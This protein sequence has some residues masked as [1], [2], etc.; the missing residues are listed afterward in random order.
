MGMKFDGKVCRLLEGC[1]KLC[2]LIGKQ[3]SG[4]ILDAD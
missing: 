4:H 3:E 1:D 2:C